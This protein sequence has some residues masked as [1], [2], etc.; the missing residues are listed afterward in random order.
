MIRSLSVVLLAYN[1]APNVAPCLKQVDAVIRKLKLTNYEIILVNDGSQD[2]TGAEAKK[3]LK[4]IPHFRIIE[5]HPNR[6]YS[7]ALRTGLDA[8][9]KEFIVFYPVDMQ[10]DFSEISQLIAN[11]AETGADL[12]SGIRVGGGA[13]P[14]IRK[15]N[16]T[17]WNFAV[18]L[19]FGKLVTDIDCGFKLLKRDILKHAYLTAEKGAMIDTQLLASAKAHGYRFSEIPVTHLP[20][21]AGVATGADLKVIIQSFTDLFAYWWLLKRDLSENKA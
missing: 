20:R 13:D 10:F 14:F 16:R 12:V 15:L 4:K 11:Q 17:G 21:T 8:S 7:G 3:F 1:E 19:L 6:G 2:Q 9:T 5:N 18:R